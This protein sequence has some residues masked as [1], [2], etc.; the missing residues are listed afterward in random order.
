MLQEPEEEEPHLFF[1]SIE[2]KPDYFD[3]ACSS[4]S[5][6]KVTYACSGCKTRQC[7][8]C[9]K[10]THDVTLSAKEVSMIPHQKF[11]C[12]GCF[13][14][15]DLDE[16]DFSPAGIAAILGSIYSRKNDLLLTL[17]EKKHQEEIVKLQNQFASTSDCNAVEY[18]SQVLY[19]KFERLTT[20]YRPC[21]AL[22]F[23]D[24]DACAALHCDFCHKNFCAL[25]LDFV[26]EGVKKTHDE[27][28]DDD[29]NL[30]PSASLHHHVK[31][32]KFNIHFK[33][34]YFVPQWYPQYAQYSRFCFQ[35][36]I[37]SGEES[38]EV[39]QNVFQKLLP[40]IKD[41]NISFD[42]NTGLCQPFIKDNQIKDIL[43]NQK[44]NNNNNNIINDDRGVRRQRHLHRRHRHRIAAIVPPPN[45]VPA[46]PVAMPPVAMPPV[47][48]PPVAMPPVAVIPPVIPPAPVLQ[49]P[50]QDEVVV[51]V[52]R[53]RIMCSF[54]NELGYHNKQ[55]CPKRRAI[56]PQD[57]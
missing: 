18:K 19:K 25:C 16:T 4:C 24:F 28:I 29:V 1:S 36:N 34:D 26:T 12:I 56:P 14:T 45:A 49:V 20:M 5:F 30:H 23:V 54:C 32:C 57:L 33:N 9:I 38:F 39:L 52:N 42:E 50:P 53:K 8:D 15:K 22:A 55:T 7:A 46:P 21:C 41:T 2:D 35:W 40:L 13:A 48:M 27:L 43:K 3:L 17:Q 44:N 47:A 37:S 11:K 31:N 10:S 6:I 51:H